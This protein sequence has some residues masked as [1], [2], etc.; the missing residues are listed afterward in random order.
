M[1]GAAA[2]SDAPTLV[3]LDVCAST[4]DE[5]WA[6]SSDPRVV[7]VAADTQTGG[8]GRRGRAWCSPQGCGLYL[9]LLVRPHF[10]AEH[11]GALPLLAGLC[12][13]E[14]ARSL[15]AEPRLKWPNDVLVGDLKLAGV[16]CE[17]RV[18]GRQLVAVVGVGLNLRAPPEGY[19]ADVPA[20]A[21]GT[22]LAAREVA[23]RLSARFFDAL[24]ALPGDAP[25]AALRPRWQA[26][27]PP[28]GALMRQAEVVGAYAGLDDTGG[29]LLDTPSGRV[30]LHAG[31]VEQHNAP[32]R[33]RDE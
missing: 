5:A 26:L 24:A 31:E 22:D 7:G 27:G 9:S 1:V 16:L 23:A 18:E 8:R 6:R 4:N 14:L 11:A 15:D 29:L 30:A 28:L 25:I 10:G 12:V 33:T 21:L 17:A 2:L 20:T 13:A 32:A 19:P 3:W